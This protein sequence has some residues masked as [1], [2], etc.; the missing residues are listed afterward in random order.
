MAKANGESESE[1]NEFGYSEAKANA[2]ANGYSRSHPW[3]MASF[4]RKG[5]LTIFA[6]LH[7]LVLLAMVDLGSVADFGL[8]ATDLHLTL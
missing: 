3:L 7:L 8:L 2:K 6:C 5:L 4:S 1:A